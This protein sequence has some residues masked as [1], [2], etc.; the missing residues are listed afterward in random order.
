[1]ATKENYLTLTEEQKIYVR[2]NTT[3]VSPD[4]IADTLHTSRHEVMKFIMAEKLSMK[5][6]KYKK[7]T[8]Q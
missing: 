4:T 8:A 7:Q 1:M 2:E 5:K 6:V 3:K